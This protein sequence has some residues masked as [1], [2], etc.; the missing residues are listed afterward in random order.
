MISVAD[1]IVADSVVSPCCLAHLAAAEY[2]SGR[3]CNADSTSN[4]VRV[5]IT[6][7]RSTKTSRPAR[8]DIAPSSRGGAQTTVNGVATLR[9]RCSIDRIRATN[10][11][12]LN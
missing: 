3:E 8:F 11:R 12:R 2:H 6:G 10:S 9:R 4:S 1:R 7:S 5:G